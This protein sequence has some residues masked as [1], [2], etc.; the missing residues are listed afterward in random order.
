MIATLWKPSKNFRSSVEKPE[1]EENFGVRCEK[2][3]IIKLYD[4]CRMDRLERRYMKMG[5]R[6]KLKASLM[7]MKAMESNL[8]SQNDCIYS[9]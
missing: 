7:S 8:L 3:N 2:R 9:L 4:V 6:T 5:I 1:R